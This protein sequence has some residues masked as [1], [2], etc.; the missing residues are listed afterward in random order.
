M[1][2]IPAALSLTPTCFQAVA[3]AASASVEAVPMS[4]LV[5]MGVTFGPM[6]LVFLITMIV[7]A[8]PSTGRR[9]RLVEKA[10]ERD[11]LT[12]EERRHLIAALIE[13]SR[14][15]RTGAKFL[16][17]LGWFGI[18][19]GGMLW[20]LGANWAPLMSRDFDVLGMGVLVGSIALATLP[21]ALRELDD[22]RS[23]QSEEVRS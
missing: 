4:W 19:G 20:W 17:A 9:M 10:L 3:P 18:F 16:F 21:I 6:L 5:T 7:R 14:P 11:D 1:S 2:A 22:R 8:R 12:A 15:H 13:V 23:P